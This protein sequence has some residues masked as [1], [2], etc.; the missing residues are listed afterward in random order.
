ML[1]Q[2]LLRP[3]DIIALLGAAKSAGVAGIYCLGFWGKGYVSLNGTPSLWACMYV[4]I[5]CYPSR[6]TFTGQALVGVEIKLT[7]GVSDALW[8]NV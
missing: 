8:L 6:C 5:R 7:K 3:L 1:L 4:C 2:V